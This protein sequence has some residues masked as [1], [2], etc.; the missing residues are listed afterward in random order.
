MKDEL[1][2][3]MVRLRAECADRVCELEKQLDSAHGNR[4]SSMFQMKEEVGTAVSNINIL[5][6]APGI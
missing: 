1:N 4:M 5:I 6:L 2:G 3:Q